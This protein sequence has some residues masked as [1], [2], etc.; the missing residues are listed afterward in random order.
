MATLTIK[1]F[2]E[3]LYQKLKERAERHRRSMNNEAIACLEQVIVPA[4][5]EADA[6]IQEAEEVDR[7]VQITFS[8][9]LITRGKAAGRS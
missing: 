5:R 8:D 6:L 4:P 3:T 1:G 7:T 2:P 9:E